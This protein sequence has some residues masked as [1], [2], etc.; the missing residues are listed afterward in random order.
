MVVAIARIVYVLV[1]VVVAIVLL[2]LV[3]L[4][5]LL[6]MVDRAIEVGIGEISGLLL[7]LW[8]KWQWLW[9]EGDLKMGRCGWVKDDDVDL[10]KVFDE[11]MQVVQVQPAASIV[12]TLK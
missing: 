3:M 5:L 11:R 10:F 6:L 7:C 9:V 1:V 2:L 12:S 8:W 4:V